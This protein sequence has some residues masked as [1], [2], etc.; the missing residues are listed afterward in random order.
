LP[1][2]I[3]DQIDACP[4][5]KKIFLNHPRGVIKAR[6]KHVSA[7]PKG[8]KKKTNKKA[9]NYEGFFLASTRVSTF[10]T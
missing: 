7:I 3:I 8:L 2:K 5:L 9:L 10:K 4:F 6:S 1:G